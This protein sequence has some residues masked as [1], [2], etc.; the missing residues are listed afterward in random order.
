MLARSDTGPQS[1]KSAIPDPD[2]LE[3]DEV[4]EEAP[5]DPNPVDPAGEIAQLLV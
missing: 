2:L 4:D 5:V 3:P 1:A